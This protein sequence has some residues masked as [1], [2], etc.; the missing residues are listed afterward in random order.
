VF[1]ASRRSE[2][3]GRGFGA[4]A[5]GTGALGCCDAGGCERG[6]G[7]PVD[8]ETAG[9]ARQAKQPEVKDQTGAGTRARASDSSTPASSAHARA[10]ASDAAH[11]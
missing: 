10:I 11:G 4:S 6:D 9:N 1:D 2:P 8:N 3:A 7:V 5:G